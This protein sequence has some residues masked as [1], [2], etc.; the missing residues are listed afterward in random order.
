MLMLM[1]IKIPHEP[2]NTFVRKGTAGKTIDKILRAIKPQA[3]YFTEQDGC[4]AAMLVVDIKD[5]A[6]IP[7]LAEPWFLSFN[8]DVQFRLAMTPKDLHHAHLD[9]VSKGW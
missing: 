5:Q 7:L 4:R 6:D 2:F 3:A 9:V 1:H 8:A